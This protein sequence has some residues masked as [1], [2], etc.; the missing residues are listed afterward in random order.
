MV[1]SVDIINEVICVMDLVCLLCGKIEYFPSIRK[2][3]RK[4]IQYSTYLLSVIHKWNLVY[5]MDLFY[6]YT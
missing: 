6:R 4:V 3:K 5:L 1:S 2:A